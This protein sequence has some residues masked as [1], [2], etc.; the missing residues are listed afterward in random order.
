ML[1]IIFILALALPSMCIALDKASLRTDLIPANI[2]AD[3]GFSRG[4]VIGIHIDGEK[5]F[6][7]T[8]DGL[9]ISEDGGKTWATKRKVHGLPGDRLAGVFA[10]GSNIYVATYW[11][12][13]GIS[14]DGGIS[15]EKKNF[16]WLTSLHGHGDSI[17]VGSMEG[18]LISLDKGKTWQR[19]INSCQNSPKSVFVGG[20]NLFASSYTGVSI[21]KDGGAKWDKKSP[22]DGL[23]CYATESICSAQKGK[24][25]YAGTWKGLDISL[26][27]GYTFKRVSSL[28]NIRVY[29]VSVS[30]D[31]KYIYAATAHGLF[32]S[33][34]EGRDFIKIGDDIWA[35]KESHH[36]NCTPD[37]K[38][39]A[40]AIDGGIAV[41]HDYGEHWITTWLDPR[42]S[43]SQ[44]WV[45]GCQ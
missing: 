9:S 11:H 2:K 42:E 21:T 17:L 7:A 36:V 41:S 5:I 44:E 37:G 26:D 30:E 14:Q 38:R 40:V 33:E 20:L 43:E 22:K 3:A 19:R 34:N 45:P 31:A 18:V 35:T 15:W 6:A 16:G 39:V 25:V 28:G 24:I 10:N 4:A 1:K 12:G 13:L 27:H 23:S 8:Y 29:G 32:K